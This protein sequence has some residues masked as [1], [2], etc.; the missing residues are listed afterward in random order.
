MQKVTKVINLQFLP[1]S[2][3]SDWCWTVLGTTPPRPCWGEWCSR[4]TW[5]SS[6]PDS[7]RRFGLRYRRLRP[8]AFE[9]RCLCTDKSG[10]GLNSRQT[11][12]G[13]PLWCLWSKISFWK[14]FFFFYTRVKTDL[15]I[16][17]LAMSGNLNHFLS[18][19]LILINSIH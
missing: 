1:L 13:G 12:L 19:S 11:G 14:C 8:P 16:W 10:S 5:P 6:W 3:C 18:R 15:T 9:E 2:V 7:S 4:P 17:F